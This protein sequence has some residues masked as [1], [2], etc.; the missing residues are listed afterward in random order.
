MLAADS[1]F[2]QDTKSTFYLNLLKR[3]HNS[4]AY[5]LGN[6][7]KQYE[8]ELAQHFGSLYAINTDSKIKSMLSVIRGHG[9]G[10][11]D[12]SRC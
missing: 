1:S 5:F 8:Y 10:L 2:F 3:I 6:Y 7:A 12:E 9:I 4:D 11:G